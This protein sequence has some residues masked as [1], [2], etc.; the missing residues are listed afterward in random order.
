ME[1][2]AVLHV[3]VADV[4]GAQPLVL[5]LLAGGLA[6]VGNLGDADETRERRRADLDLVEPRDQ[7][8]DGIGEL[9][10]VERDGRH[11]TDRGVAGGD[12]PAAPHE[13]HRHRQHV[14]DV[15]R[16]EQ[17]RAEVER[18]AL[19]AVGVR[20]VG[21]D[22]L[23][24]PPPEAE[25]V[26]RTAAVDRLADGAGHRRV[27]GA[28][29]EV[30][31]RRP[32][33]VPPRP[34]QDRRQADDA[35]QRCDRADEDG[36]DDRQQDRD[37]RDERLR[38]RE[39]DGA[40]ERVDV[41]GRARDEIARARA[42]DHGERQREHLAH[43]VLA[44]IGEDLLRE[45]ERRAPREPGQH[46]LRDHGDG[47]HRDDAVDVAGRRALIHRLDERAE[48]ERPDEPGQS[49]ERVQAEHDGERAAVAPQQRGRVPADLGPAAIGSRSVTP[50]PPG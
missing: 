46:R 36:G 45:H 22:A 48:Q 32:L 28:L 17:D 29:P 15:D 41:R 31:L 38:N 12:E 1:D 16:R 39:A 33:Q 7:T 44:Q 4:G 26:D 43:E 11:L 18:P 13:R 10:H 25:R 35:R 27:G 2:V 5:R 6:V 34:D 49:G 37:R 14:G 9:L 40:R 21:V 50:R 42:L 24:A 3:G 8:V 19:G 20:E 30:A 23:D 47:E